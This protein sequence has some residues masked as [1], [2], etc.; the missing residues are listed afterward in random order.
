MQR[1]PKGTEETVK[2][3]ESRLDKQVKLDAPPVHTQI[4]WQMAEALMGSRCLT[5]TPPKS[6]F[7]NIKSYTFTGKTPRKSR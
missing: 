4:Q 2:A 7:D 5:Q 6:L 1:K 3:P